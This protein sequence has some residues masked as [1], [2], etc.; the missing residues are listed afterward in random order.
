MIAKLLLLLFGRAVQKIFLMPPYARMIVS[1]ADHT[2]DRSGDI[3]PANIAYD[4]TVGAA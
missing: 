3:P 1:V 4:G 2:I